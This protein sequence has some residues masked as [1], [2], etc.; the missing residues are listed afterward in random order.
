M[1]HCLILA[2][3]KIHLDFTGQGPD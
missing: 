2:E 1:F 3:V